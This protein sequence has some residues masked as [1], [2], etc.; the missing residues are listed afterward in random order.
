MMTL[1]TP[2]ID[3]SQIEELVRKLE[4]DN[5]VLFIGAG[6]S[7]QAKPYDKSTRR[8]PLWRELATEVG[9]LCGDDIKNY[10]GKLLDLFDAIVS[11]KD[12]AALEE[13]VRRAIPENDFEPTDVHKT[14]VRLP[15]HITYTTNYDNLLSRAL[16]KED[17]VSNEKEYEWLRRSK[18]PRLIHL[19][20]T[21]KDPR[22][23]S[24]T[25]YR[26]WATKNPIAHE[27]LTHVAMYKT[28][29]FAGYSF[30]DPY[31]N[32]GVLTWIRDIKGD[33]ASRNYAWMW[34]VKQQQR[35]LFRD[36]D[37]INVSSLAEDESWLRAFQQIENTLSRGGSSALRAMKREAKPDTDVSDADHAVINGY[38]LFYYRHKLGVSH[39]MLGKTTNIE[40]RKLRRLETV[41]KSSHADER[42]FHACRQNEIARIETALAIPRVLQY[43]SED[44]FSS[45]F[46]LYYK[47]H[48]RTNTNRNYQNQLP[49]S[50]STKAAVFDFGGTLTQPTH[51]PNTW[52]RLWATVGYK[53][54]ETGKLHRDYMDGRI[55]HQEWCDKTAIKLREA[56]FTRAHLE[57]VATAIRPMPGLDDTIKE[58][59]AKGIGLFIV[60][61]NV[62]EI[63]R[64]VLGEQFVFFDE[65]KAN[66]MIF[67]G[68][69]LIKEIRGHDFDF[70]GKAD[71][72][73]RVFKER[74][75][76]PLDV[77]FVGNSLND[78]WAIR[79]GAR[80]LC[81][82]PSET[83]PYDRRVW[84][85]SLRPME[86][87]IEIL[88]FV[89][90]NPPTD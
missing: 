70:E 9:R 25:D 90:G 75:C 65:I 51:G 3:P 57:Q 41:K 49:F 27:Q 56:G 40:V 59:R 20:G 8:L 64:I 35:E 4:S 62:R 21:L 37:K 24:G 80:T 73:R 22:T 55:R 1:S 23:L 78:N 84:N 33:R 36:R 52:E 68:D 74:R 87:L 48:R 46:T 16:G 14:I 18:K 53:N 71:F 19:H 42:C 13:A 2:P 15:W 31:L 5:L 39:A 88:P 79:S 69:G 43:G 58:L 50:V 34:Q 12:R 45:M 77:L 89:E 67:D 82:N 81:V 60:S 6:I 85:Y 10:D 72:L 30:S 54:R 11:R 28:I 17:F 38:K 61:G 83:D 86:N 7:H 66:D 76:D 63:I 29:L 44:D 32:D 47:I 26:S